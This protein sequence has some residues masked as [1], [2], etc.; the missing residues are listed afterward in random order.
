MSC[1]L[2]PDSLADGEVPEVLAVVFGEVL[3]GSRRVR[4]DQLSVPFREV[5]SL[6]G[7]LSGVEDVLNILEG[8]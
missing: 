5:A 7:T 6:A 3:L 8:K 2:G 1:L 4:Q